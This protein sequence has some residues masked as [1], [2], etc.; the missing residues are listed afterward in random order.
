MFPLISSDTLIPVVP[1]GNTEERGPL[2][3][4]R[5]LR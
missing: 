1:I 4:K 3:Q 5:S 2:G